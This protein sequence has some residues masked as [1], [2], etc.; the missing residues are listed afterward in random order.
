M[1]RIIH[2]AGRLLTFALLLALAPALTAE[3]SVI[4]PTEL[5]V[6][7][8]TEPP[9][10]IVI[11]LSDSILEL[12]S[13]DSVLGS[14][15]VSPGTMDHPTFPGEFEASYIIWNPSWTP[16]PDREWTRGAT[17]KAPGD[18]DNPMKVAKI[19]YDPPYYYIHGTGEVEKLGEPASHGCIRMAPEDIEELCRT[20]MEYGGEGPPEP[21]YK[22]IFRSRSEH[23]TSL[24]QAVPVIIRD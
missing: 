24:A 19:P 1:T 17:P 22:R 21:W 7:A 20:L 13:G 16:P 2:S 15:V 3:Q 10:S 14:W 11:D 8:P 18:A 4:T 12:R 9:V 6:I 23:R 5:P